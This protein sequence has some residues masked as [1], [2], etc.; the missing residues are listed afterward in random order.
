MLDNNFITPQ[1]TQLYYTGGD[2]Q[3]SQSLFNQLSYTSR[4]NLQMRDE[5][6]PINNYKY[7]T[8]LEV[9]PQLSVQK[10]NVNVS[11]HPLSY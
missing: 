7:Q 3:R 1:S 4:Q 10:E 2:H 11:A 8:S 6:T 9:S 5:D